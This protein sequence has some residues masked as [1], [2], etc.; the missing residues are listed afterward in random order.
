MAKSAAVAEPEVAD[1]DAPNRRSPAFWFRML[2]ASYKRRKGVNDL[3]AMF[4]RWDDGDLHDLVDPKAA[5]NGERWRGGL[6]NK[7]ATAVIAGKADI[8]FRCPRFVVRTP[9]VPR[10]QPPPV[11]G[12]PPVPPPPS[13]QL[14]TPELARVEEEYLRQELQFANYF[15]K[16]SRSLQDAL[17]AD[18]G[19]L[20]V[21]HDTET[22][23]EHDVL[24][25]AK[26]EC[27]VEIDEF[28]KGNLKACWALPEQV[29]SVHLEMKGQLLAMVERGEVMMPAPAEKYLR[30]HLKRHARM[31]SDESPT[32]TIRANCVHVERI[33]PLDYFYDPAPPSRFDRTWCGRKYLA[34]LDA[35]LADEGLDEVARTEAVECASRWTSRANMPQVGEDESFDLPEGMV[36]LFEV[37]DLVEQRRYLFA[38]G[39]TRFLKD[40]DRGPL[41]V[42]QPSG[43]F[44]EL[45]F[46]ESS[47]E[48]QGVPPPVAYMGDFAGAVHI[49]MS[50]VAAAVQNQPRTIYDPRRLDAK[51]VAQAWAASVGTASPI[52]WKGAPDGSVDDAWGQ[53][54]ACEIHESSMLVKEQCEAAV[55]TQSGLGVSKMLGGE[56]SPTATGAA[57][58][59][60]ASGSISDDRGAKV[61]AWATSVARHFVRLIR[62][63]TPKSMVVQRCGDVAREVWPEDYFAISDASNDV[64]VEAKVGFSRRNNTNVDQEQLLKGLG[65]LAPLTAMQGPAG[66]R[67]VLDVARE[68]MESAGMTNLQW[69]EVYAEVDAMAA[70][71]RAMAG[72][73]PDGGPPG[74]D[75]APPAAGDRSSENSPV[76]QNDLEQGVVN[77]AGG[78]GRVGVDE[79]VGQAV[80]RQRETAQK[81]VAAR[82]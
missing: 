68:F 73:P 48:G 29:H 54:P 74:A 36:M 28:M 49:A 51:Q 80:V 7:H 76:A 42:L 55:M 60:D 34:R 40:E 27:Q 66:Q 46:K 19:V 3:A 81:S 53:V 15:E 2:D 58:G 4:M 8:M 50:N 65:A 37:F 38:D 16:A 17:N 24:E 57:L 47:H 43:P 45:V 59:A 52:E 64:G 44:H 62:Y 12:M 32:E 71:Q 79:S 9:Y 22:S 5:Q 33:D 25:A 69:D 14:F 18:M 41:A 31:K 77:S 63:F 6:N 11:P 56:A 26:E 82:G 23:V 72:V 39:A 21:T 70:M 78:A 20:M 75:G 35:V 1:P 30:N 10:R 67:L 61:D 13:T